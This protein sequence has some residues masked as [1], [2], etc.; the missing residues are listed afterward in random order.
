[1]AE[2]W[3]DVKQASLQSTSLTQPNMSWKAS[4]RFVNKQLNYLL[5]EMDSDVISPVCLYFLH[6]VESASVQKRET[7]LVTFFSS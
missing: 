2:G 5:L 7:F 4:C 1:M 3:N 6:K